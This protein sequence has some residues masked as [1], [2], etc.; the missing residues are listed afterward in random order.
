MRKTLGNDFEGNVKFQV[1]KS[2]DDELKWNF[3]LS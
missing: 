1:V 2:E 3:L